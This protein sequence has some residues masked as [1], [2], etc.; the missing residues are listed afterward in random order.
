MPPSFTEMDRREHRFLDALFK[1]LEPLGFAIKA[2]KYHRVHFE[3][4]GEQIEYQLRE[5][6]RQVRRPLTEDEKRWSWNRDRGWVQELQ[7]TG[8]L[9]FTI[10]KWLANGMRT[11]W[12]DGSDNPIENSLPEIVAT[13]S[14]AGPYL[15]KQR[16]ERLEAEKRQ[17][18]AEQRRYAE[19]QL[20]ESDKARWQKFLDLARQKD[21]AD[22]ARRLLAELKAQPLPEG[23]FRD[24]SAVEWLKWADAWLLNYDPMVR[25]TQKFLE[26]IADE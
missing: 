26:R 18:E 16:L 13:L 7:P 1:V 6:L 3:F 25:G 2:D 22:S 4:Q 17:W 20:K 15:V 12:K 14:L 21:E 23:I 11:E 9:I 24:R 19:R 10:K 8:V 5:K